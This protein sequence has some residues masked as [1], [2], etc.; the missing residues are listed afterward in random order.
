M[1][2]L[3]L[4]LLLAIAV[5]VDVVV[6]GVVAAVAI[7]AAVTAFAPEVVASD[8]TARSLVVVVAIGCFFDGDVT[9]DVDN[10]VV[11]VVAVV[12]GGCCC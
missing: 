8:A 6:F 11:A 3:L 9:G 5:G 4:L 7:V 1:L 12:D 10:A 2:L